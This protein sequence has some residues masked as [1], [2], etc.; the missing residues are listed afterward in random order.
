MNWCFLSLSINRRLS[1][2]IFFL[3]YDGFCFCRWFFLQFSVGSKFS[4]RRDRT[5]PRPG[6]P[7]ASTGSRPCTGACRLHLRTLERTATPPDSDLWWSPRSFRKLYNCWPAIQAVASAL[8]APAQLRCPY[9]EKNRNKSQFRN[10]TYYPL[11]LEWWAFS[12]ISSIV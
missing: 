11:A 8:Q 3:L 7:T 6:R 9:P 5:P 10:K 4:N 1:V 12:L 2:S